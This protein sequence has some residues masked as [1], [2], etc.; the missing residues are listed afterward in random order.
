MPEQPS[1]FQGPRAAARARALAGADELDRRIEALLPESERDLLRQLS[2]AICDRLGLEHE[3]LLDRFVDAL[4]RHFPGISPAIRTVAVHV[5][6]ICGYYDPNDE[7]ADACGLVRI[8]PPDFRLDGCA[9]AS[10]P[11]LDDAS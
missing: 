6:G 8:F 11:V 1:R 10:G 7:R 9:G 3:D 2:D 5:G 4:A